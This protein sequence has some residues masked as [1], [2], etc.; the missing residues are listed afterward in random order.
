MQIQGGEGW[1]LRLD[2]ERQPFFLLIGGRDWAAELT[3][4]EGQRLQLAIVTLMEQLQLV[5]ERLMPE[6]TIVLEHEC[7]GL[8]LELSGWPQRWSLR[9]VL[10]D[11]DGDRGRLRGLEGGWDAAAS[12]AF[13]AAL[14]SLSLPAAMA[15][16][17]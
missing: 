8:W 6:E 16:P 14:Q 17:A 15:N 10:Q 5:S 11:P 4:P 7:Q 13:A 3:A 9:F 1:R 12:M 2:P